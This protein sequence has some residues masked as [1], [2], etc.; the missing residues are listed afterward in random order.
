MSMLTRRRAG[1]DKSGH[2]ARHHLAGPRP[3]PAAPLV[4]AL[5]R[6]RRS[7]HVN[8]PESLPTVRLAP[9]CPLALVHRSHMRCFSESS[10]T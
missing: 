7:A 5:R 9:A 2:A 1:A 10:P 3:T 8:V 4:P 6:G